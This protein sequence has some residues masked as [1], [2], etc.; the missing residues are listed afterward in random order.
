MDEEDLSVTNAMGRVYS[1][2][3]HAFEV[4]ARDI[5]DDEDDEDEVD[6]KEDGDAIDRGLFSKKFRNDH[7]KKI[8][9]RFLIV[10]LIL[11]CVCI[12]VCSIYWGATYK[13]SKFYHK[14]NIVAVIEDDNITMS[15]NDIH[16][17]TSLNANLPGIIENSAKGT[18]HMY[19]TSQFMQRYNLTST[20]EI[21]PRL[22]KLI[23]DED[24]WFA[25][26]AKPNV[27]ERII[28]SLS[29]SNSSL[30]F[31]SQKF[32]DIIYE[33]ARDGSSLKSQMLIVM[34]DLFT[35]FQTFYTDQYLPSLIQNLTI[36]GD[37]RL[38]VHSSMNWATVGNFAANYIDYRPFYDRNL[39]AP[40]QVGLIFSLILTVFQLSLFGALHAEIARYL[41]LKHTILYRLVMSWTTYL[42]LSLYFCTISAIFQIDFTL[43]F[44]K[45]GFIVYWMT[46]WLVMTAVGGANENVLNILVAGYPEFLSL[47]LMSWIILNISPSFYP[48]VLTSNFYRYGYMMPLYNA[49][50]LFKVIFLDVSKRNMGRNYGVLI[51][52]IVLNSVL[53]PI[54]IK[55]GEYFR[56]KRA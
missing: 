47:W 35:T 16:S 37:G 33:S 15:Q 1:S 52:W 50:A 27:T 5:D 29:S 18:W 49:V 22:L 54:T 36:N 8:L 32:Y 46:M 6:Y 28:A 55:L 20:Q 23:Y 53:L 24:Y 10:S 30:Q 2:A 9:L 19:N 21:S 25:L 17:Y 41:G 3:S 11:A 13:T 38:Q 48:M 12:S 56:K 40:L 39:L 26:H 34:T 42:F 45:A 14:I 4:Q 43:A 7:L 31:Q 44:G 51:A